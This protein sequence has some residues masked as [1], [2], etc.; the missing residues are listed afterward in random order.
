VLAFGGLL[1]VVEVLLELL[2]LLDQLLL[3]LDRLQT[4]LLNGVVL[5]GRR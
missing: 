4:Q 5:A 1:F 2:V 3:L